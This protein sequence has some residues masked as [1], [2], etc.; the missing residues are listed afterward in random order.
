MN[1]KTTLILALVLTVGIAAV[2]LLDK[3]DEKQEKIKE[4]EGRVIAL[5]KEDV[6]ALAFQP[7]GIT[8]VK[9]STGWRIVEPVQAM[10]DDSALDGIVN[11]FTT[12]NVERTISSDPSEYNVFGLDPAQ[13][14]IV[15]IRSDVVDTVFV[16]DK[17]PTGEFQ[18]A[19]KSGTP[20][21]FLTSTS[22]KT[23]ADKT[24]YD[25]RNKNVLGFTKTNVRR[26]KLENTTGTFELSKNGADWKLTVPGQFDADATEIDKLLNRLNDEEAEEFIDENPNNLRQ[27]G[28]ATPDTKIELLLGTDLAN[29]TLLIGNAI[30]DA[31]YAM[32][33]SRT[34]VFKVDSAFVHTFDVD[35][36]T[37]RNKTIADFNS[38]DA[39]SVV[40]EFS[41]QTIVC[42]KDTSN[43]WLTVEPKART[44]KSWKMRTL[45]STVSDLHVDEFV[46]EKSNSLTAYGLHQ[47]KAKARIYNQ[48]IVLLSLELGE[49]TG[50]QVYAKI[51]GLD[52]I[53][54]IDQDVFDKLTPELDDFCQ[55]PED[56]TN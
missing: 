11:F 22:L 16:G 36:Y 13:S 41:G 1:F 14:M 29:K 45:L 4:L 23:N 28:L 20:Q 15:L 56:E 51:S 52:P 32:D 8:C 10:G 3:H 31:Y 25:L 9:D 21:V 40:L 17:T 42:T 27:Y 39:D 50:E 6:T 37:L 30:D 26:L 18:F 24:L 19:R 49:T 43:A 54:K 46:T 33:E 47:P 7:S 55:A 5:E 34:P 53:Y 44:V 48:G 38:S 2:V 12:A 35:L